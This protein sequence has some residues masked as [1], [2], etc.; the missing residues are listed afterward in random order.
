MTGSPRYSSRNISEAK[1]AFNWCI[2]KFQVK[3][4]LM[5]VFVTNFDSR[6]LNFHRFTVNLN[7]QGRVSDFNFNLVRLRYSLSSSLANENIG[8][9]LL[10]TG[11]DFKLSIRNFWIGELRT[12]TWRA[13]GRVSSTEH[14]SLVLLKIWDHVQE[15]HVREDNF[16]MWQILKN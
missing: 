4:L 11:Q 6:R 15:D 1:K 3:N 12:W 2:A 10:T 13:P 9:L 14:Q 5:L 16:L 7:G 8:E